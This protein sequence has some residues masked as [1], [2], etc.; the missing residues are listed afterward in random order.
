MPL[1]VEDCETIGYYVGRYRTVAVALKKLEEDLIKLPRKSRARLAKRLIESLDE[2]PDPEIEQ[3][4]IEEALR[5]SAALRAGKRK[6][7]PA[8]QVLGK[9]RSLIK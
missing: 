2:P 5:R 7:I 3:L 1:Q 9:A 4:W 8:S 6:A